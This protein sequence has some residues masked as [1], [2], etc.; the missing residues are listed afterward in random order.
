MKRFRKKY[1]KSGIAKEFRDKM[2]Y[3]KPSIQKRKKHARAI[4]LIQKEQEKKKEME[5][6]ARKYKMKRRRQDARSSKRQN[7]R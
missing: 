6:R 3:E 1:S 4:R 2:Y 5:E 7:N